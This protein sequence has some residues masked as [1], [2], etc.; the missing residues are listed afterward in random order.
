MLITVKDRSL[1]FQHVSDMS[2][3]PL[4]SAMGPL[5][6]LIAH[7][8]ENVKDPWLIQTMIDDL[9]AFAKTLAAQWRHNKISEVDASE[10]SIFFEEIALTKTI[11]LLWRMLRS[12]LFATAIVLR[13]VMGR[14]LNDGRLAADGGRP[15][16]Y[17][18]DLDNC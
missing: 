9:E 5:S 7:A 14:V 12:A 18:L 4:V 11:P 8:A 3:R 17:P 15:H 13:G 1:S 16:H 2:S 10:E 6:R